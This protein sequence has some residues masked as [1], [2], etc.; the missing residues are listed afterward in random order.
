[1]KVSEYRQMMAYLTR[2]AFNGGG[3]VKNKT[4]LPKKKPEEEVKKRKIKNFEKAKPA[5]ENPKEVKEMIDKPK[6]GLVDEPGSYSVTAKEQKNI[7]AWNK[8]LKS[9]IEAGV[10]KPYEKQPRAVRYKIRQG[11]N[12]GLPT[13]PFG[14]FTNPIKTQFGTVYSDVD[15]VLANLTKKSQANVKAWEKATGKKYVDQNKITRKGI[16][17]K[18]VNYT[19]LSEISAKKRLKDK[20]LEIKR[21][22]EAKLKK[23]QDDKILKIINKNPGL[24][25]SQIAKRAG[26]SDVV[27]KRVANNLG[28]D[29]VTKY[30]QLLPELKALDKLIKKN[31]KFLSGNASIADKRRFLFAEMQKQFGPNYTP[32][33]FIRR[34]QTLG[35]RYVG[36][37][38]QIDAYKGF[39]GPNNYKGSAL[40]KNIV[41]MAKGSYLGVSAE[42]RLLGLPKNQI[43]LLDDVLSGASKLTKMKV[44][45]DHTDINALMKDFPNY[46][47]NF[48]R[49]NII[50]D[51]LNTEKLGADNQLIK[52]VR[53]LNNKE[54]TPQEFTTQRDEIRT[55]FMNKTKVPI[56]NPVTDVRGNVS[57][58]FQTPRLI[59]LK[60]P[61]NKAITQAVTNLIEQEGVKFSDFDV[62]YSQANTIK[63]RLN[64]LK[65]ATTEALQ[66]SKIIKGFAEMSGNVGKA[67]KT[68]LSSKFG[69][70]GVLPTALYTAATTIA[71]ADE[72]D[73]AAKLVDEVALTEGPQS[74]LASKVLKGTA[75]TGAAAS[76]KPGRDILKFLGG[77][78]FSGFNKLLYP[79][80][81]AEAPIVSFPV[82]AYK[83]GKLLGDI[84]RGE[85][86][87]STAAGIT[88]SL[89][90]PRLVFDPRFGID[91]FGDKA[92]KFERFLRRTSPSLKNLTRLAKG[93][94]F[95]TPVI[96]TAIQG[97]N[98]YKAL[99]EANK[100]ASV[101]EPRVDTALGKAPISY[102]NKIM[103]ELPEVDRSSA[104]G[105]G[106]M[107]IAGKPSGPPPESG[108]TP[109]GLD[110]LMKRGR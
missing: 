75:A 11:Q 90:A 85:Q 71:N 28:I 105:G 17:L 30:D 63:D 68:L 6:R 66:K 80:F 22:K 73:T 1:M 38:D 12:A 99:Q 83:S 37:L 77:K 53:Q 16:A 26:V 34:I 62:Q 82:A 7:N 88:A 110:F 69:K 78:A 104:A 59:D 102:Y 98:A 29:L 58:D 36:Q 97:Y 23:I 15:N 64:L 43:Q 46:K 24:N 91:V 61:R 14:K 47:K 39:K 79:F 60:N 86:T 40:H 109:Q 8:R 48:T 89:A 41:G 101:F 54:I 18:G 9:A 31:S 42:A 32:D 50:S 84:K 67:A 45:G 27:V 51:R 57:L 95:A 87:D 52:L 44:A 96:E 19:P 76:V 13:K 4:V 93:S 56:G 65:N 81:A 74:S 70:Y 3:S 35:N 21:K 25:A 107:K 33:E 72:P 49:I 10:V 20:A 100:K 108:P 94:V 92:N 2:P 106:I 55:N 5:L 103:S